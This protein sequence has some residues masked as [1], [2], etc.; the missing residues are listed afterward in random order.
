[1]ME[2]PKWVNVTS[3][4]NLKIG[5]MYTFREKGFISPQISL[6]ILPHSRVHCIKSNRIAQAND[7]V[8]Y[9]PGAYGNPACIKLRREPEVE[10]DGNFYAVWNDFVAFALVSTKR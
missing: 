7:I 2:T 5:G 4:H 1:M 6:K 9:G 8:F 10:D 3:R